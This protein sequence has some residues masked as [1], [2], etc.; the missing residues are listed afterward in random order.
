MIILNVYDVL[1]LNLSISFIITLLRWR[2]DLL[3]NWIKVF[4]ILNRLY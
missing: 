2:K 1:S 4:L 3:L